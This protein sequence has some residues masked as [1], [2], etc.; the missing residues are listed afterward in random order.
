MKS[1]L[2]PTMA[3]DK[4]HPNMAHSNGT[5]AMAPHH[6][7]TS[8]SALAALGHPSPHPRQHFRL[9]LTGRSSFHPKCCYR[10]LSHEA[11]NK[12]AEQQEFKVPIYRTGNESRFIVLVDVSG[13]VETNLP[14]IY[15][16]GGMFGNPECLKPVQGQR[17]KI[18]FLCFFRSLAEKELPYQGP[19]SGQMVLLPV[20]AASASHRG[21]HAAVCCLSWLD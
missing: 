19:D 1:G 11:R 4:W 13:N 5:L 12:A 3:P 8:P 2:P 18:V 16:R 15:L 6:V 10:R 7:T 17:V 14:T 9:C 21:C 20:F